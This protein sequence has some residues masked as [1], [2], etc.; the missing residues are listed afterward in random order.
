MKKLSLKVPF[1]S[2]NLGILKFEVIVGKLQFVRPKEVVGF[3]GV[4]VMT[5]I[6]FSLFSFL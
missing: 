4:G 5:T 2:K 1:G 6:L 3:F